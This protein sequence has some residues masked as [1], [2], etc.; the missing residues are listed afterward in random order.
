MNGLGFVDERH[1]SVPPSLGTGGRMLRPQR[2]TERRM[3][4]SSAYDETRCF[5]ASGRHRAGGLVP[6]CVVS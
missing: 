5:A 1:V 3:L 6:R 2:Y 4:K